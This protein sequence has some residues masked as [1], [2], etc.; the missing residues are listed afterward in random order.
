MRKLNENIYQIQLNFN[1]IAI[2][3]I[4]GNEK[5][6]DIS[7]RERRILKNINVLLSF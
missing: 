6:T 1:L 5:Y 4:S 7:K 2:N 3:A